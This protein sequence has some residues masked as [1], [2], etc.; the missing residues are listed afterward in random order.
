MKHAFFLAL[1]QEGGHF[2]AAEPA[3]KSSVLRPKWGGEDSSRAF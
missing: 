2:F 3:K 1:V